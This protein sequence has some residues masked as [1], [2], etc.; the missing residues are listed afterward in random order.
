MNSKALLIFIKNPEKGKVKTR[1]AKTAGD[2][3]AYQVYLEL[4]MHTRK[5]AQKLNVDRLLFY[6]Q[7][8]NDADDWE[9][10]VFQKYLQTDGDLGDRMVGAFEKAFE[11]HQKVVIIGSDCASLN[12]SIV[13]EAFAALDS[14]DFV[15]G[16]AKDGGYYLLGMSSLQVSVFNNIEW[17]TENVFAYTLRNIKNLDGSYTLM[18]VL[19]DIDYWEDWLEY[20]WELPA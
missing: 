12:S 6:S 18:P 13:E 2:E 3:K 17:S 16:P 1:I 4:S 10:D 5:I 8:I 19:S 9:A 20:G 7:F 15:L 14:H 11:Q